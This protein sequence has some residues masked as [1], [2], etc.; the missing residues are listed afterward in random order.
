MNKLLVGILTMVLLLTQ[1]SATAKKR[2]FGEV[3]DDNVIHVKLK[4]KFA[5]DKLIKARDININVWKGVVTLTGAL[6][7]QEEI[8]KAIEISEQQR[9]V[10]EVKAYLVLA[11]VTEQKPKE[12]KKFWPMFSKKNKKDDSS[13]TDELEE[14]D[15]TDSQTSL[16]PKDT[17]VVKKDN[18]KIE[19]STDYQDVAF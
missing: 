10:R 2:S 8:N 5:K 15:I 11:N 3:T 1:C 4:T 12:S 19:E 18:Q 17:E 6:D 7:S 13:K 16:D 14:K 9:G